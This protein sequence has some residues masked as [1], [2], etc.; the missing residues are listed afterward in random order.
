MPPRPLPRPR[1]ARPDELDALV[2]LEQGV[3]DYDRLSPRQYRHHLRSDSA[4]IRVL[5][6]HGALLGAGLLFLRRGARTARLYSLAT[7]PAARGRGVGRRL[8]R[9][10]ELA[11][12]QRGCT[13]LRLEVRTDNAAAIALY[14]SAGYRRF[15]VHRGYYDDGADAFR[16]EKRLGGAATRLTS[17]PPATSAR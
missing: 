3:F 4:V 9:A 13:R 16:Y 2:A 8:L 6:E 10:L 14:E 17:L 5:A 11:A 7:A 12:Q 1:P 15:A